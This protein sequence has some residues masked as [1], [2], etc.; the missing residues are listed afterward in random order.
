MKQMKDVKKSMISNE[1]GSIGI[2]QLAATV[3]VIVVIGAAITM[4]NTTFLNT[5][6]DEVWTLFMDEI[7][8]LTT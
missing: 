8:D 1:K 7:K 4:I 5:W 6:I 2:K 3:A